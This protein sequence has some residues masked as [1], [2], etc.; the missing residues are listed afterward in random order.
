MA[1]LRS[2]ASR[3]HRTSTCATVRTRSDRFPYISAF[4]LLLNNAYHPHRV[5]HEGIYPNPAPDLQNLPTPRVH[6]LCLV[7]LHLLGA[8]ITSLQS[9]GTLVRG[10]IHG[11]KRTSVPT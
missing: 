7:P 8:A 2:D 4:F 6:V 3:V 5:Q 11:D 10:V 1:E 9:E